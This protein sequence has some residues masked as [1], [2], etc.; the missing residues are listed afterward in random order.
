MAGAPS[1]RVIIRPPGERLAAVP[2]PYPFVKPRLLVEA[3]DRVKTGS[4]L[5]ADKKRPELKFRSPGGGVVEE[6]VYGPRRIIEAIVI[7]GDGREDFEAFRTFKAGGLARIS[8]P[9]LIAHLMDGGLWPL[10]RQLPF[11]EIARLDPPPAAIWVVLGSADPFQP[12]PHVY[13]KD[14]AE[15][16]AAGVNVLSRLGN[17]VHI[18]WYDDGKGGGPPPVSGL[19]HQIRGPYPA[20]D[21][22][23]V[24]YHVKTSPDANRDW[25]V[26]GQDAARIGEFLLTGTYPTERMVAFSD[27]TAE[28]SCHIRTRTGIRLMDLAPAKGGRDTDRWIVGGFLTGYTAGP[29]QYLDDGHASV[30]VLPEAGESEFLG[31]LRPGRKKLSRSRTVLASLSSLPLPVSPELHGEPRPCVNC[32]Y[33]AAV[34]PVAILPQYLFK[35]LHAGEMEEALGLGLLDCVE[36]GLCTFVCPSKIELTAAFGKARADYYKEIHQGAESS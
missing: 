26:D 15:F 5:F 22:G 23:V 31:F 32:G 6:I 29:K 7:A 28:N 34:C 8:R 17:H 24:L 9:D 30:A 36:C 10:V 33:C 2:W 18:V 12:S 25:Y 14:R 19:T 1:R 21:P 35:S 16:F 3:G 13:L 20:S 27:G 4:V 11:R